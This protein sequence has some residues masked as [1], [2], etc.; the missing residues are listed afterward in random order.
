[1]AGAKKKYI[2]AA[3]E[4]IG[5]DGLAGV[6]TRKI[7]DEI[8]CTSAALYRHFPDIN[9]LV[10]VASMRFLRDYIEDAR[11]LSQVD[12]NP[13]ELNLQLWECLA[14]YSFRNAD[15]FENLFFGDPTGRLYSEAVSEY[16]TQYPEDLMGLKE[17]M[18]DLF[19]NSTIAER[20]LI[21]LERAEERGMITP[22]SS[23]YLSKIDSY[24]YRGMLASLKGPGFEER[25]FREATREFMQL[26]IKSYTQQLNPGYSILVVSPDFEVPDSRQSADTR[27]SYR[28]K[29]VPVNIEKS[30]K[31]GKPRKPGKSGKPEKSEKP[32][33]PDSKAIA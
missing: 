28:V 23:L 24:L 19:M 15:L 8:G 29:I 6:S 16:F 31:L 3:C 4:L 26:I 11:Q 32:G 22:E 13:L 7:A 20:D 5:R 25:D 10:A 2:E 12:L 21:L 27:S 14:Y 9:K 33:K 17:F 30:E 18:F 1:M